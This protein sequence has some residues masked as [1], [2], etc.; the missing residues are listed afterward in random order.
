MPQPAPA[1]FDRDAKQRA[2]LTLLFWIGP[3]AVMI[4]LGLGYAL[5][6][7]GHHLRLRLIIGALLLFAAVG[8]GLAGIR[9]H[10]RGR[11]PSDSPSHGFVC[12]GGS[13]LAAY[14]LSVI[15]AFGLVIA[16]MVGDG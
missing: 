7:H 9:L 1:N 5:A 4:A 16:L 15:A 8:C 14:C 10:R 11:E 3:S 12:Y 13:A 6:T 2:W